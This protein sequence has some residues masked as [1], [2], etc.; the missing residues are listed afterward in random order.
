MASTSNTGTPESLPGDE[1]AFR[2]ILG[3]LNFSSGKPDA[4]FQRNLNR[5]RASFGADRPWSEFQQFLRGQLQQLQETSPAFA[6]SE[7]ATAVISLVFDQCLP[8]YQR[9]HAD[10]L[11]HLSDEAFAQ[12]FFVARV[13]EAVLAQGPPWQ[14]TERIAGGAV[15]QL[16]DFLGFRPLAVLENEREMQPYPHERFRP[17]PLY[18]REAGVAVGPYRDLIEGTIQFFEQA[19]PEILRDA[20]FDLKLLDELALDVRAHD[21]THPVNKRTNYMFGEWDPHVIDVKGRY[22]RFV[23][24]KI[25]LDAL[26]SWMHENGNMPPKELLYDASAVLSGTILMASAISGSG[27]ETHD[28]SVTLTSLLSKVARQRDAFYTRL[29]NDATGARAKRLRKEAD[30]TQQPFGHV[31]Q[32][33]NMQL[34]EY[35]AQQVQHRELAQLFARMGYREASQDEALEIPSVSVRFECEAA[36]RIT[37][38]HLHLDRGE[39]NQAALLLTEIEDYLHRGIG[40]GAFV[41]PWNILGFQAHFPLFSSREDSIPDQRVETLLDLM[42]QIFGVYSRALGEAAAQG[43]TTLVEQLLSRFEKLADFWDQ[44]ATTTVGELPQVSGRE[45]WE[46]AK[47]VSRAL[48]EWS[49]AGEAAGDISFWRGHVDRFSSAKAYALVVETL[50]EKQD[51]VAAMG[52]L[53]QWLSQADQVGLESGPHSI[54]ALLIEWMHLVT[55]DKGA[56]GQKGKGAEGQRDKGAKEQRDEGIEKE[57]SGRTDESDPSTVSPAA[58]DDPWPT[59]R[60]LFDYLEANAGEYW[61]VP[62]LGEVANGTRL[63]EEGHLPGEELE[64]FDD[65]E[66]NLFQA[67]YDDVI[68]RDSA[69]DGH[70]GE[71]LDTGYDPGNTEFEIIGRHVEPRLR[72]LNTLAQLWQ[73]AAVAFASQSVTGPAAETGDRGAGFPA[74]HGRSAGSKACLTTADDADEKQ[75]VLLSWRRRARRLEHDLESL[76]DAIWRY[77]ISAGV[78]DLD[79]NVEY[80][81]QLQTKFYLLYTTIATHVSCRS[82]ERCLLSCLPADASDKGLPDDERQLVALYRGIFRRDAAE[83]RRLLPQFL[84]LLPKKPLLYVPFDSGGRPG[85]VLAARTLQTAFR[86]LLSQLPQL[87]LL[88]ETRYLITTAY[89]MERV[90]RPGGPAVTEFDRL[91]RTALRNSLGC[92]VDSSAN[93]ASGN[94]SDTDLI[95]IV[96]EIVEGYIELWLKQSGTMRLSHVEALNDDATFDEV[97]EFITRYGADLFHARMLTLGNVRAILHDGIEPFLDYLAETED[98]LHPIRLLEDLDQG[99]I[100]QDAVVDLL[101]LIYGSVVD[102]FECFLEYN[103]TTT[104]SDYGEQFYSLLDFLRTEAAYERDAWNLAPLHIAHEV[105]SKRQ[106]HEAATIWEHVVQVKTG[107]MAEGHLDELH[108]LE[109][110]YGMRLPAMSDHLNERLVKPL[111]VNRMVALVPLAAEDARSGHLAKPSESFETL[112]TEIDEY[113]QSTS[114]SGI[115]V[116]PWLRS[117]HKA[118]DLAAAPA[119]ADRYNTEPDLKLS[120]VLLTLQE[121]RR[122]LKTWNEPLIKKPATTKNPPK[123]KRPGN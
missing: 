113:I 14:E 9:H 86:F 63:P 51:H 60:R 35:G 105:L 68:F 10:L 20:H 31:R 7:Q 118:L 30:L 93:W 110:T 48:T 36:W 5:L 46:S 120:P 29:L 8:A 69:E 123:K 17:V 73:I 16:N 34:A 103:T 74:C 6:D 77:E 111:A 40:C 97:R 84:K 82:A 1:A 42:E 11:F 3:Y 91:F 92:V 12:P 50:L 96:G 114:G 72:F 38:A 80:D 23:V 112:R 43:D 101:E 106:K 53:M 119:H 58:A 81:I 115:D 83:V 109:L 70:L 88:H 54:H 94:F 66:E 65:E 85:Q 18:I 41:D 15:D 87:G 19:P 61:S 4:G 55:A 121:T 32:H 39:L 89:R 2:E 67:A 57:S 98:P 28:S 90:A 37:S 104:Q 13:C 78:G 24:R 25:I 45:S 71:T 108:H 62:D 27:P 22:R 107:D 21:H 102:K 76:L 117:L 100:D 116:P 79:S 47:H 99:R 122:Q 95:D 33:L 64:G 26:L 52:L 49:E 75:D 44:F 56:E 59:V